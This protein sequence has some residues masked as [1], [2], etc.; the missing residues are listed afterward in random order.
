MGKL[1]N[2]NKRERFDKSKEETINV[3][4]TEKKT[5]ESKRKARKR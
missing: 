2:Q 4:L 1:N 3:L 5:D